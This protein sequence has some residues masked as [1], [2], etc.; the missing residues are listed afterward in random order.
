M[1]QECN[2]NREYVPL[3]YPGV[4]CKKDEFLTI[5]G[6]RRYYINSL[7]VIL[8]KTDQTIVPSYIG[9]RGYYVATLIDDSGYR[10][11]VKVHRLL[12]LRFLSHPH[13][14]DEFVVNHKDTNKLNND[15]LNLEWVSNSEN[16][17]HAFDN[18]LVSTRVRKI[19][20]MKI[21]TRE[22]VEFSS[23]RACA[24]FFGV[25][26]STVVD[27]LRNSKGIRPYKG[28]YLKYEDSELS[29][30][31][32]NADFNIY[33]SRAVL[34]KNIETEEILTFESMQSVGEFL[35]AAKSSI[36]NQL[37][38]EK[39]RPY[40]GYLLRHA[41][42][43]VDWD[44]TCERKKS[45]RGSNVQAS[46]IYTNQ[47]YTYKS[48]KIAAVELGLSVDTLYSALNRGSPCGRFSVMYV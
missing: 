22:I 48:P 19:L 13:D 23:T 46:D 1:E 33:N 21:D 35:G 41:S 37:V 38:T 3:F 5:P 4:N 25:S 17:Q 18:G 7:G 31:E 32:E 34:A 14:V 36:F 11:P 47:T 27:P 39:P 12:A 42:E 29:W 16:I 43:H 28:Y 15:L 40:K 24:S 6:Y 26:Y 44:S 20:A 10:A 2:E 8:R 45:N 9:T 30:P